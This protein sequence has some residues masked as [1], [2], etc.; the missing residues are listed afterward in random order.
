MKKYG[1]IYLGFDTCEN[2]AKFGMTSVSPSSRA[3]K[4]RKE[5]ENFQMY[6]YV[7]IEEIPSHTLTLLE[8]VVRNNLLENKKYSFEPV[9][10][11]HDYISTNKRLTREF[12][13]ELFFELRNIV[14]DSLQL[15]GIP[16]ERYTLRRANRG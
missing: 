5:H 6:G 10:Q 4:I 14:F 3:C 9:G 15:C 13:E 12:Q 16:K 7:R 2:F 8:S 11:T 1:Y